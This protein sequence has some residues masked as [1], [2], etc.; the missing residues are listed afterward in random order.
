M[1]IAVRNRAT[2]MV[3]ARSDCE[4]LWGT[5]FSGVVKTARAGVGDRGPTPAPIELLFL[6]P[7][8]P[9]QLSTD[10]DP[11]E[12]RG[13]SGPA[14]PASEV[15]PGRTGYPT[16]SGKADGC[17]VGTFGTAGAGLSAVRGRGCRRHVHGSR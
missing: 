15:S 4:L 12:M 8:R 7:P 14:R 13:V 6:R 10:R 11:N 5:D 9:V 3:P 17:P 1:S 16:G 2:G